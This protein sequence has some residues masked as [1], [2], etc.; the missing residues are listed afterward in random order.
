MLEREVCPP[1]R[2]QEARIMST[3]I[4]PRALRDAESWAKEHELLE[5]LWK[6]IVRQLAAGHRQDA[7]LHSTLPL[8][9]TEGL[10]RGIDLVNAWDETGDSELSFDPTK[11]PDDCYRLESRRSA[12]RDYVEGAALAFNPFGY[13]SRPYTYTS[14]YVALA[15]DWDAVRGDMVEA[16]A[17]LFKEDPK[18]EKLVMSVLGEGA[19][20]EPS[21]S[22]RP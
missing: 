19:N 14:D 2:R 16:W 21:G 11:A 5:R 1:L 20:G 18:I 7:H 9:G 15:S 12:W 17:A 4:A 8:V 13:S 22:E 6:D 10:H 3:K